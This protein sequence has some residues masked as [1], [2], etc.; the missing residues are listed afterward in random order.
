[1][2]VSAANVA[3][4]GLHRPVSTFRCSAIR[5]ASR[6]AICGSFDARMARIQS[7]RCSKVFGEA[8]RACVLVRLVASAVSLVPVVEKTCR[9]PWSRTGFVF[10]LDMMSWLWQSCRGWRQRW[11]CSLRYHSSKQGLMPRRACQWTRSPSKSSLVAVL[12]DEHR[13]WT[14][15]AVMLRTI[16][17]SVLHVFDEAI[18]L[19]DVLA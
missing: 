4:F 1:M 17:A 10:F 19:P 8:A 3:T 9:A 13:R 18:E 2:S 16:T 11:R 14:D 5:R 15:R 7:S 12:G 6:T